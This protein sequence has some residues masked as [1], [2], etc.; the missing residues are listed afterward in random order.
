[1]SFF[2]QQKPDDWLSANGREGHKIG[3]N[4]LESKKRKL[5]IVMLF[6]AAAVTYL[7]FGL[8]HLQSSLNA[9]KIN[10]KF[11]DPRVKNAYDACNVPRFQ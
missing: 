8:L 7:A 1:M 11:S 6:S 9:H 5:F 10:S 4:E 2:T 3:I